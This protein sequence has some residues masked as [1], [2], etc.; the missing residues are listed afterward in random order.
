MLQR[1]H[2]A[3]Q[4]VHFPDGDKFVFDK[5]VADIFPSMAKRAIPLF[6][7]THKLHANLCR[8][9]LDRAEG[10]RILDVGASRGAFLSALRELTPLRY[11]D[12]I[13]AM[14]I[15]EPM[16]QHLRAEYP[17][18]QV[19]HRDITSPEFFA[20]DDGAWDIINCTYVVQFVKP[21][22]QVAVLRKLTRMLAPGGVLFL[23]QKMDSSGPVGRLLHAEYI[24]FRRENGYTDEEIEAKTAALQNSMW[25]MPD[26]V[27][28]DYLLKFGVLPVLTS[29]WTV[30][31]NY[32]CTKGY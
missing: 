6:Y 21:E 8:P 17:G 15:S 29:Q 3:G 19:I 32:M 18:V 13:V 4:E 1:T 30:F 23:G 11:I 12:H 7:E 14:D 2:L 9:W 5:E 31:N 24:R 27:L 10:V 28:A 26:S 22:H 16:C 20:M 25:P